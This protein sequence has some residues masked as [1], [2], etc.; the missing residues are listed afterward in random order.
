MPFAHQQVEAK[1]VHEPAVAAAVSSPF[2]GTNLAELKIALAM[3]AATVAEKVLV[4][5]L[6]IPFREAIA[7]QFLAPDD[8]FRDV[9]AFTAGARERSQRG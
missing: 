3:F 9:A 7:G 4:D 8:R 2:L 5:C 1:G 6:L